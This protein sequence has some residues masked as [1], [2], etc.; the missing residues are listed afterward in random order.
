[1]DSILP[2][3]VVL[4]LHCAMIFKDFGAME[5]YI[6][7]YCIAC[8]LTFEQFRSTDTRREPL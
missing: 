7:V 1:M 4:A 6:T 5:R 3:P 2:N 8:L